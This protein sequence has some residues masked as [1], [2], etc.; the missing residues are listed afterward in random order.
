MNVHTFLK[1]FR[2]A[3]AGVFYALR[4]E[5]NFLFEAA[6][7]AVAVLAAWYFPLTLIE[8]AIVLLCCGMVLSLELIN[9]ALERI[10]DMMKPRVHPYVRIIK[11][12]V[13]GAVL[14][15]AL[16]SLLAGIVIFIPHLIS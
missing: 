10:L 2:H 16:S 6:A 3:L 1:S 12:L 14:V 9:T 8:R 5:Q 13:A 15:S 7:A 4:E 11:D